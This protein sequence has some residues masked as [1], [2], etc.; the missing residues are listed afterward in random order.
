MKRIISLT[1]LIVF[2]MSLLYVVPADAAF[3]DE[4]INMSLG[5]E[6]GI[7]GFF[8]MGDTVE[9]VTDG[10]N[11]TN[12]A[13]KIH[14]KSATSGIRVN[15]PNVANLKGKIIKVSFW[16]KWDDVANE[17]IELKRMRP[18]GVM[19]FPHS[20][21]NAYIQGDKPVGTYDP[22]QFMQG[23]WT[24]FEFTIPAWANLK[25]ADGSWNGKDGINA[26]EKDRFD[27]D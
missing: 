22:A 21:G 4:Q 11:G 24:Y 9:H 14:R 6:D 20:G 26:T 12:G 7:E 19:Y 5:F 8:G 23:E 18:G 17:G 13:L 3:L 1:I 25:N 10:A 27:Y 2:L 15:I 16:A